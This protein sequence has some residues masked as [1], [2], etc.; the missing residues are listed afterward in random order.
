MTGI[1]VA[2]CEYRHG[3]WRPVDS[4]PGPEAEHLARFGLQRYSVIEGRARKYYP[5]CIT[6]VLKRAEIE[7]EAVGGV[8]FFTSTFESYADYDDLAEVCDH[9]GIVNALPIGLTLGQCTNFSTALLTA[10]SL[11]ET[12]EVDNVVLLGADVLDETRSGRVLGGRLSV[13]SDVVAAT[14][15]SRSNHGGYRLGS[16][17]HHYIPRMHA[18]SP[19]R[20]ILGFLDGFSRGLGS[21]CS[22]VYEAEGTNADQIDW[23]VPA[24]LNLSVLKNFAALAGVPMERTFTANV[25]TM[26]HGFACD[27]LIALR[28]LVDQESVAEGQRLLMIGIGGNYLFSA[29]ALTKA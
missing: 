15:V 28:T 20:D 18:I 16:I 8:I 13:F 24:N 21:V 26:G 10:R 29:A 25:G 2:P 7:P 5:D 11:I 4:L 6:A 17:R 19:E 22:Q 1:F 14:L 9:L 3:D 27:Q 12:S 23:L